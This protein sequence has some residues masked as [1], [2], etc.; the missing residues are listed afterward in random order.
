MAVTDTYQEL[1]N[2][3]MIE[4][5]TNLFEL[6]KQ[7]KELDDKIEELEAEYKPMIE[8]ANRV[9]LFYVLPNG[10]KFNIKRAERKG[11]FNAKVI[12]KFLYDEGFV[13]DDHVFRNKPTVYFTLR[14]EKGEDDE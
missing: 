9:E 10:Q 7:K 1:T 11:S 12:N 4:V 6:K 13:F 5:F 14:V 8:Q 3:K 2:G